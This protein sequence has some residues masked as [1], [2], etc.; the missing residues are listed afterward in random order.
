MAWIKLAETG[1]RPE[2]P[3]SKKTGAGNG[4][5]PTT[6]ASDPLGLARNLVIQPPVTRPPLSFGKNIFADLPN[7]VKNVSS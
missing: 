1:R 3:V 7:F 5:A 2:D 6:F 4:P